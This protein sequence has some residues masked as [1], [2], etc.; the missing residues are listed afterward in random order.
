MSITHASRLYLRPV[1]ASTVKSKC[2]SLQLMLRNSLI[3]PTGKG[4]YA[5]LPLGQRVVDKLVKIVDT[6]LAAIGAQ[7]AEVPALATAD[8]WQRSERL[9]AMGQEMFRLKDRHDVEYCLQPTAEEHFTT[10]VNGLGNVKPAALPIMLYQTSQKFRDEMSP[11]FGLLRSRQFLMNDLYTFDVDQPSAQIT[12]DRV[13]AMYRRLFEDILDLRQ[14]VLRVSA[15]SGAMGGDV[16]HEFHLPN[17][18]AEDALLECG[19]C[20]SRFKKDEHPGTSECPSCQK[21]LKTIETVEVGHTFQLGDRYS[22]IFEA[23]SPSNTPYFMCC[24][25]LGITRIIAASIDVLSTASTAMRLPKA[26]APF[27][28]AIILPKTDTPNAQFVKSFIP[29]LTH[30]PNLNGEIL[31]DDRFDKSIG[32]R[33]NEANQLGIEHVLVASSHKYVDPTEVQ[34]VEYFKTSAGS[35]SI[36]KVGALTHGEIFDIFSKV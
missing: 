27:K 36:D 34:R 7:K 11:R 1:A 4:L 35:A 33:I 31:L 12:Y 26:I 23:T 18:S 3:A 30:L 32:R 10:L 22:K 24:F 19:H 9:S 28:L 20:D 21:A 25:G 17:A 13:D 14:H 6:E 8:I 16:S 5:I 15:S 29:Q 2:L